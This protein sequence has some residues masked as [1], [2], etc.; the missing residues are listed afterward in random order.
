MRGLGYWDGREDYRPAGSPSAR[1]FAEPKA[2]KIAEAL[3][4]SGSETLLDVGAGTGH[5]SE[6]FLGLGHPVVAVDASAGMLRRNRSVFRARADALALPFPDGAFDAVVESNLLHHVR[7]PVGALREMARVSRR[8]VACVEPNRNH[9][10]MAL[11]SLLVR[12]ERRGLRFTP[13]H[14]G[15]LGESAG[16]RAIFLEPSGWVY[17]N[18]TPSRLAALLGRF[19]G[20]CALAAYAVGVF[21]KENEDG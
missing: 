1:A 17:Q 12:E 4:L 9:P 14:L 7:D 21:T 13:G 8:G 18:R 19:N 10:P 16:L 6:A 11:F 20:R 3:R 15:R 5:L 2:R